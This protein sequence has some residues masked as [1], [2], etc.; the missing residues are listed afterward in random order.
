MQQYKDYRPT[1]FDHAGL[2]LDDR[3]DWYVVPV[4]QN[5][6]SGPMERSNFETAEKMLQEVEYAEDEDEEESSYENHRF[7]HW[8]CGW[9]EILIVRP[10][11]KCFDVACEIEKSLEDYPL[12]DEMDAS[13]KEWNEAAEAW[14]HSSIAERVELCQRGR[15][16]IFAARHDYMPSEESGYI[17]ERLL[18]Y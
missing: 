14:E 13:E 8:A 2:A 12:L 1:G 5:R 16:S 9:F 10:G 4:G 17:R 18:G 7:G 3:Q 15:V 6:D 11:S